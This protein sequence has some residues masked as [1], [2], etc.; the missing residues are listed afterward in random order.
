[1]FYFHFSKNCLIILA[2]GKDVFIGKLFICNILIYSFGKKK[3]QQQKKREMGQFFDSLIE[4]YFVVPFAV[5]SSGAP[6]ERSWLRGA[7]SDSRER[8]GCGV[9]VGARV[10]GREGL[11]LTK[12]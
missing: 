6:G 8:R 2:N 11:A 10:G 4:T 12:N 1:M 3:K 7:G 5:R 9:L